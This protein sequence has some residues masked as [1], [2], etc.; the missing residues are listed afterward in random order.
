VVCD[1]GFTIDTIDR[2]YSLR[3]K[4]VGSGLKIKACGY[5]QR[6]YV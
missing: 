4:V 6:R 5:N 1:I 3:V 2:V